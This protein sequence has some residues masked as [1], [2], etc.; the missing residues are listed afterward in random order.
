MTSPFAA[1]S[2]RGTQQDGCRARGDSVAL[3]DCL[4]SVGEPED[5]GYYH[6]Q[7]KEML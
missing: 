4:F 6:Y 7:L 3:L 1:D 2:I 5:L